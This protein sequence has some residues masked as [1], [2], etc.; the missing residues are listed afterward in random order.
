MGEIRER[1]SKEK[2]ILYKCNRVMVDYIAPF[3]QDL[4]L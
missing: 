1:R 3:G 4:P 2:E